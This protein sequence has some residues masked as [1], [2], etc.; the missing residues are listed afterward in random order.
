MD[1][2]DNMDEQCDTNNTDE[3]QEEESCAGATGGNG[4]ARWPRPGMRPRRL[5]FI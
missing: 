4:E 1:D 2:K 3:A 5:T